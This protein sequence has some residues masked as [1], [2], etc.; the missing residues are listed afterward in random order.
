[1]RPKGETTHQGHQPVISARPPRVAP[2]GGAARRVG[3]RDEDGI[4]TIPCFGWPRR[5]DMDKNWGARARRPALSRAHLC[6]RS[7]DLASV[8]AAREVREDFAVLALTLTRWSLLSSSLFA[9]LSLLARRRQRIECG[10]HPAR[11]R[12]LAPSV[13]FTSTRHTHT[14]SFTTTLL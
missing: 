5:R 3:P 12:S 7:R 13:V 6:V 9:S 8:S 4:I 2:R 1:M 14:P 11:S 10:I